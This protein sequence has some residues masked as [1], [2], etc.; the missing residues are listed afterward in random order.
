[1]R[2]GAQV[3]GARRERD[4]LGDLL[5]ETD[6]DI[7]RAER[8]VSE[9]L[10]DDTIEQA[11]DNAAQNNGFRNF[12]DFISRRQERN[13]GILGDGGGGL[14]PALQ[15]QVDAFDGANLSEEVMR[16]ILLDEPGNTPEDVDAILAAIRGR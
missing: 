14:D 5:N 8:R 2:D 1:M 9:G 15:A 12:A 13:R 16:E 4:Q 10:T 11:R 7:Q 6:D 3:Q